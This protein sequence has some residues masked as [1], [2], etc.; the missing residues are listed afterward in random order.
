MGTPHESIAA[1]VVLE[2]FV[3]ITRTVAPGVQCIEGASATVRQAVIEVRKQV[4][5]TSGQEN[6]LLLSRL[7]RG[8]PRRGRGLHC[9][10]SLHRQHQDAELTINQRRATQGCETAFKMLKALANF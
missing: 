1:L 8:R 6:S 9:A 3:V 7:F 4:S 10:P 2:A 5:S